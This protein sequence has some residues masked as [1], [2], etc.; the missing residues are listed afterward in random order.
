MQELTSEVGGVGPVDGG[1]YR[2]AP[3]SAGAGSAAR[4]KKLNLGGGGPGGASGVVTSGGVMEGGVSARGS[5]EG[6]TEG[7][8]EGAA[9]VAREERARGGIFPT[10]AH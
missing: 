5:T 8:T 4:F 7:E 2:P 3:K 6:E 1:G 10:Y 9:D